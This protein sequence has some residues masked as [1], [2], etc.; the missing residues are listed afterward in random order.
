MNGV[1][2]GKSQKN[3]PPIH[4][5]L[6]LSI[7]P[8]LYSFFSPVCLPTYWLH[9]AMDL[10]LIFCHK[11]ADNLIKQFCF[12][13]NRQRATVKRFHNSSLSFTISFGKILAIYLLKDFPEQIRAA[14]TRYD[15]QCPIIKLVL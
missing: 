1:S 7:C 13:D 2:N 5:D 12:I 10:L 9:K 15:A 11:I 6:L 8:L 3:I 4:F 14:A